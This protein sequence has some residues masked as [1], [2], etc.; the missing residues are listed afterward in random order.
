MTKNPE[1]YVRRH[2]QHVTYDNKLG[3]LGKD[4]AVELRNGDPV[5]ALELAS[6]LTRAL[7]LAIDVMPTQDGQRDSIISEL[8]TAME[9]LARNPSLTQDESRMI[10]DLENLV[11]KLR[12][13]GISASSKPRLARSA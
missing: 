5:W 12:V 7:Q 9:S 3:Y 10:E 6:A 13:K 11:L 2:G 4:L 8:E 1:K